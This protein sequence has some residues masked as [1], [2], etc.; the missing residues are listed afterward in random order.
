M[1]KLK[2]ILLFTL[3]AW[4]L[5]VII[6]FSRARANKPPVFV[7]PAK[8]YEDGGSAEYY[9]L[10]YKVNK[11]INLSVDRG[12]EIIKVDFGTWF[13]PFQHPRDKVDY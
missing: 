10:G 11:Y 6:D 5:V 4:F 1:K 7:V 13:M 12:P 2:K 3:L 8:I 9:G